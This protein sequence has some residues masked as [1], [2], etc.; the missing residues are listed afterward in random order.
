[1]LNIALFGEAEKG[2]FSYPY[3]FNRL[4]SLLETLGNP[5]DESQG[6]YMAIQVLIYNFDLIYFRVEEEGFSIDHYFKG[7]KFLEDKEKFKVQALA[8]PG[9]GNK[10][11]IDAT[12]K[13][14]DLHKSLLIISSK[15]LYD[16]LTCNS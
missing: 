12:K 3:K 15:D 6:L 16:Y 9:V 1:M 14:C 8:M 7:L 2:G 10:E 4:E 13:V 5:P 11:L